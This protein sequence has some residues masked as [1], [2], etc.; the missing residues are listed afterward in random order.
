M[1][2]INAKKA[3]IL[4]QI[5]LPIISN[6]ECKKKFKKAG[7]LFKGA[8]YRF[9][10]TYVICAGYTDGGISPCY[11]DSGGPMMLPIHENGRFPYYQIGIVSYGKGKHY[12]K[13]KMLKI[14]FSHI[15]NYFSIRLRTTKYTRRI[16]QCPK[17][18]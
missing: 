10:E 6:D 18:Y 16:Y 9:N 3:Q 11:G 12:S 4:Q 13:N 8:N 2:E 15:Y 14:R 17:I 1:G 5:Q 7:Y